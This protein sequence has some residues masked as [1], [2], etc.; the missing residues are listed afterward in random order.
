MILIKGST[1]HVEAVAKIYEEAK[2]GE[3]CVWS[4]H[5]PTA[6][7]AHH[8][9]ECGGLYLLTDGDTVVG[10]ASVEEIPED[11]DLPF[12]RITDDTHREIARIAIAPE[13]QG[14]GYARLMVGLLL[15]ELRA[16]GARSVHLL[17]APENPPAV[18]T[19]EKL[20]FDRVG[21]CHRYG[22]GYIAFEKIL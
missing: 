5:Y 12:W 6:E 17:A 19:Y 1:A 11:N 16:Q 20:G 3:F 14:R 18:R 22:H 15:D 10:C 9:A 13:Y 4:E 2:K 21:E 7:H 8:D